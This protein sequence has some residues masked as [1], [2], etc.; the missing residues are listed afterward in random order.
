MKPSR[1]AETEGLAPPHLHVAVGGAHAHHGPGD[2]GTPT[3]SAR[4][5]GGP[6]GQRWA[7]LYGGGRVRCAG[8][9]AALGAC[10]GR[11]C[12]FFGS[13]A[14]A[15]QRSLAEIN[16]Q[17]AGTS[18]DQSTHKEG[19]AARASLHRVTVAAAEHCATRHVALQH[20]CC[21]RM[22][23]LCVGADGRVC[24]GLRLAQLRDLN[25]FEPSCAC[26]PKECQCSPHTDRLQPNCGQ[27][28]IRWS[29]PNTA[30][31]E[32]ARC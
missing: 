2:H 31:R 12:S 8:T 11:L 17:G 7:A 6:D 29:P 32:S 3:G 15:P 30:Q 4:P 23:H 21:G 19:R 22:A 26:R 20:C 14:G 1:A 24:C 25:Q 16:L 10:G 27:E 5:G 13:I 9:L 18:G 28:C